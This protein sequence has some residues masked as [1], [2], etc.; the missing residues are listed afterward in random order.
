MTYCKFLLLSAFCV[1]K[2]PTKK[3]GS[4][5]TNLKQQTKEGELQQIRGRRCCRGPFAK[6]WQLLKCSGHELTGRP[7]IHIHIKWASKYLITAD[8]GEEASKLI[9]G[10]QPT[11]LVL[12]RNGSTS[13]SIK[14]C[15]CLSWDSSTRTGLSYTELQWAPQHFYQL[16]QPS[17]CKY[18]IC[19]YQTK[20]DDNNSVTICIPLK[21]ILTHTEE[22]GCVGVA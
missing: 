10:E 6:S 16:W 22:V 20:T 13:Q 17:S 12:Q 5:D 4:A 18:G 11:R 19:K 3:Q 9:F 2:T 15:S 21:I 1:K 14:Y 8:L 7:L